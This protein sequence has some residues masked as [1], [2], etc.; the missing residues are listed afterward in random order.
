MALLFDFPDIFHY[1][2]GLTLFGG[3]YFLPIEKLQHVKTQ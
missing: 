2:S 3:N 1:H